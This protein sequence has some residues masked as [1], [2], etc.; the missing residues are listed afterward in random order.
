MATV[1][2]SQLK[3][4]LAKYLRMAQSGVEVEVLD[5]GVPIARLVGVTKRTGKEPPGI[6]RLVR[7]GVV[8][9]GQGNVADLL[10]RRLDIGADLGGALREDREDR[11]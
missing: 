6:E 8:R 10:I 3:A 1:G 2:I 4:Q 11:A 5:R 7:A 9:R